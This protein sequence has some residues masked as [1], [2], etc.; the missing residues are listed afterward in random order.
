MFLI[1]PQHALPRG[2]GGVAQHYR[3]PVSEPDRAR[4]PRERGAAFSSP[5]MEGCAD[6]TIFHRPPLAEGVGGGPLIPGV[7]LCL[8]RRDCCFRLARPVERVQF[9]RK[10]RLFRPINKFS[11][12][13][14]YVT[15]PRFC[16]CGDLFE[17]ARGAFAAGCYFVSYSEM[18]SLSAANRPE[19]NPGWLV[20]WS[21]VCAAAIGLFHRE[22]RV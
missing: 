11:V 17:T 20:I 6:N 12:F 3:R 16:I 10:G 19:T 1:S 9:S 13:L 7:T 21:P 15:V 8:S 2:W 5:Y 22:R 14:E 18:Y 4:F